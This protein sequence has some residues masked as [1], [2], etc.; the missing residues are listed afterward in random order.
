MVNECQQINRIKERNMMLSKVYDLTSF[1]KW[2]DL[3]Y[4]MTLL[5]K[6][7][8]V[9]VDS[10]TMQ[11]GR[12][13]MDWPWKSFLDNDEGCSSLRGEEA[14]GHIWELEMA[15]DEEMR[16]HNQTMHGIVWCKQF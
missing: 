2:L 12:W 4:E 9:E 11:K 3:I 15:E 8:W 1:M 6:K 14:A 13:I 16:E 10:S 7:L 5:K